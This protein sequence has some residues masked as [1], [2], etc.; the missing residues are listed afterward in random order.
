M[1]ITENGYGDP[2]FSDGVVGEI[3]EFPQITTP[4]AFRE[5]SD[6]Q[7]TDIIVN[8]FALAAQL[9]FDARGVSARYAIRSIV[10]GILTGDADTVTPPRSI[11]GKRWVSE[12][13][14]AIDALISRISR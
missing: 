1:A 2:R 11:K 3:I 9:G 13:N 4:N 10:G 6:S 14:L 12:L 7:L 8:D 5:L